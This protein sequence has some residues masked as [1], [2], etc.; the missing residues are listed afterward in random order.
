LQTPVKVLVSSILRP[1]HV[2][3]AVFSH[4]FVAARRFAAKPEDVRIFSNAQ[5][6]RFTLW[7]GPLC[8]RSGQPGSSH[9]GRSMLS[10][11]PPFSWVG[12]IHAH[13]ATIT[14]LVI[15]VSG[16]RLN[17]RGGTGTACPLS[18]ADAATASP[19]RKENNKAGPIRGATTLA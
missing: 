16:C 9:A 19:S 3:Q 2:A 1:G 17:R 13:Q 7:T 4:C 18:Q 10:F 12:A 5:G 6:P 14:L 15:V 8:F 11:P